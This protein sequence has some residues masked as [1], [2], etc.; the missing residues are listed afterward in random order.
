MKLD[1]GIAGVRIE[2]EGAGAA[3][4]RVTDDAG[5]RDGARPPHRV[6]Q[7]AET[8]A[9]KEPRRVGRELVGADA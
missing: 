4:N 5:Q 1:A 7:V 6:G 3:G 2:G 8:F 9:E